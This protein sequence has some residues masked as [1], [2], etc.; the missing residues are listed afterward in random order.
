MDGVAGMRKLAWAAVAA[1]AAEESECANGDIV[2]SD[3]LGS[4]SGPGAA[5]GSSA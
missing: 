2:R 1:T 5:L 4:L 3:A